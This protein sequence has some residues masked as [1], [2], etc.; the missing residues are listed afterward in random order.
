M[1]YAHVKVLKEAG[2]D[3][4]QIRTEQ[5]WKL[6]SAKLRSFLRRQVA[7]ETLAEDL[8]QETFVRVHNGIHSLR[9]NDRTSAWVF[10]IAR[11]TIADHFRCLK[12]QKPIQDESEIPMDEP[13]EENLNK[14]VA[15]WLSTMLNDLPENYREAVKLFELHNV[16]QQ[17]IAN[18]LG[19]S[20]SGAKSRVQRGREK[21]KETLLQCCHFD[22]DRRGNV[23]DL[24]PKSVSCSCCSER[25]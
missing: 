25:C 24:Q 18:R 22:F 4:N 8:L 1:K 23:I 14:K 3:D 17:E 6:L 10:R 16:P 19:L 12:P 7:D 15:E 20:L 2:V 11:N 9:E 5:I 21:L 13:E